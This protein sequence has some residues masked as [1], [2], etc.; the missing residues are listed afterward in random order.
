MKFGDIKDELN[1]IG[2]RLDRVVKTGDSKA[3]AEAAAYA[4]SVASTRLLDLRQA[5]A[6]ISHDSAEAELQFRKAA[7]LTVQAQ[8]ILSAAEKR[9]SRVYAASDE[10]LEAA[11]AR[12]EKEAISS[13]MEK[14]FP[15]TAHCGLNCSGIV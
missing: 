7:L 15:D 6:A 10:R 5:C 8:Q 14:F 1:N 3:I 9:L 11:V 13:F 4:K 12:V 2:D